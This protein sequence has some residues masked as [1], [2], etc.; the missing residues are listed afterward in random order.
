MWV[1]LILAIPVTV[2]TSMTFSRAVTTTVVHGSFYRDD[3]RL[4][5]F[6]SESPL[7]QRAEVTATSIGAFALV[8]EENRHG[9]PVATWMD[10]PPP[11]VR[12]D[13][14]SES[15]QRSLAGLGDDDPMHVAIADALRREGFSDILATWQG[16]DARRRHYLF[17]WIFGT[18]MW[19][20]MMALVSY[21][22]ISTFGHLFRVG[23]A[24]AK[25]RQKTLEAAGKCGACGYDM[26]GLE[27][28]DRCPEC[29]TIV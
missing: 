13:V 7:A 14:F 29:G 8:T 12:L 1:T 10:A 23:S 26:Q 20:V 27:F 28:N 21:I 6:T 24:K 9:W 16:M 17:G 4:K 19:W 18:G 3:G 22:A 2:M 25:L 5:A 15:K 11:Q